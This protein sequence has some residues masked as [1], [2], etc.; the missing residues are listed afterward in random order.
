MHANEIWPPASGSRIGMANKHAVC[1]VHLPE[2]GRVNHLREGGQSVSENGKYILILELLCDQWRKPKGHYCVGAQ[3]RKLTIRG[4]SCKAKRILTQCDDIKCKTGACS[5]VVIELR[6][7]VSIQYLKVIKMHPFRSRT[8]KA[9]PPL[10][11]CTRLRFR[12]APWRRIRHMV[13]KEFPRALRFV[14]PR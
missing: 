14:L 5:N 2:R 12:Y 4:Y 1:L 9:T 11:S 3:T 6:Y 8:Q 13:T 10:T 7:V